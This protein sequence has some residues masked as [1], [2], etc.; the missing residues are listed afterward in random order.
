M[1]RISRLA[2]YAVVLTSKMALLPNESYATESLSNMTGIP[3]STTSK[4]LTK[5]VHNNIVISKRGVKGGYALCRSSMDISIGEIISAI[6]G[7]VALTLCVESNDTDSCSLIGLC[8]SQANWK[9]INDAIE[10]TLHNI[11]LSDMVENTNKMFVDSNFTK[12]E[13]QLGVK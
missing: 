12:S 9:Q 3:Y 7:R 11:K 6:D 8:P 1:I 10:S 13:S 2:D 5:L 4:I